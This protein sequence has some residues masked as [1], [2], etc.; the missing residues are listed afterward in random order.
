MPRS[1]RGRG[2]AKI[3]HQR[4]AEESAAVVASAYSVTVEEIMSAGRAKATIVLARQLSMYLAHIVG[5]MSLGQVSV[6]FRRD[7][8]TVGYSCGAIEDRRDGPAFDAQV[9]ELETQL[10]D[11]LTA[12]LTRDIAPVETKSIR[13][14]QG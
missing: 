12:L 8:T 11:R 7:R 13:Y 5:Q 9:S 6:Q 1:G 10:A 4:I 2:L 3:Y 14:A